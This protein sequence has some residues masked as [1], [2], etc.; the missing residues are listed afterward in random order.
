VLLVVILLT[1]VLCCVATREVLRL[2]D[3]IPPPGIPLLG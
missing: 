3:V 1:V 2:L